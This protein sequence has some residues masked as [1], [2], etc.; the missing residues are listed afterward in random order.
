MEI[1]LCGS[2]TGLTLEAKALLMYNY[3][4]IQTNVPDGG[5]RVGVRGAEIE[6]RRER[7]TQGQGDSTF[8]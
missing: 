4:R 1:A 6:G 3:R 8:P 7:G 5:M 2:N